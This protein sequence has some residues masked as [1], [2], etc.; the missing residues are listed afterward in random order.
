MKLIH[1]ADVHLDSKLL[2][3][4]DERK[5]KLRREE[6]LNTFLRMVDYAAENDVEAIL[7][8]GD[9]FDTAR[10]QAGVRHG[11]E[12]TILKHPDIDFYL[13]KGNHSAAGFLDGL[14]ELP[15][16]LY[17]F[18]T[19]W[20]SFVLNPESGGNIVLTGA[21]LT[22]ESAGLLYSSLVLDYDKFNI[23]M[24]HG[25][26]QNYLGKNKAET[27]ALGELK[28]KG[29]D[30]LALG[31]VHEYH[32]EEL[33]KRGRWCYPGCLEGR[34]FDECGEHGFVLL[35]IEEESL[36]CEYTRVPFATRMLHT[37]PVDVS[38][39]SNSSD[40]VDVVTDVLAEAQIS[41][42]DMVKVVLTG[43][44]DV[45]VEKNIDFMIKKLEDSY[46]FLKIYDETGLV[47][48]FDSF[49]L[50][51]SLKGE[52]VRQ[53]K[54]DETMDEETKAAVIRYGLQALAG[55]VIE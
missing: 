7:I 6:I 19:E 41:H 10:V 13:L 54:A 22:G 42:K 40:M 17:L 47:V 30:Y 43:R 51:E 32:M 31:H 15:G 52:F 49:L 5:A 21:E 24:L 29:I 37:V 20:T 33:D 25:Q 44:L 35:D 48:D 1:C 36:K 26:Q 18:D 27:I 55:E 3:N 2:A 4:L 28:N 50:D 39:C 34:G 46:F 16:N 8:A 23:V 12:N 45:T 14:A 11:V 9:L 38:G 53:V